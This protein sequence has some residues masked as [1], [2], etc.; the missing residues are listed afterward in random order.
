[1]FLCRIQ[2]TTP[3][4]RPVPPERRRG[5]VIWF[6]LVYHVFQVEHLRHCSGCFPCTLGQIGAGLSRRGPSVKSSK[7]DGHCSVRWDS[8]L[9][10]VQSP[11]SLLTETQTTVGCSVQ[12]QIQVTCPSLAVSDTHITHTGW[13]EM[14]FFLQCAPW[15]SVISV[16]GLAL[17]D[18]QADYAAFSGHMTTT[19]IPA[20]AMEQVI[21]H[22]WDVTY[23]MPGGRVQGIIWTSTEV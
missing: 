18:A 8:A 23:C 6:N 9:D 14:G 1:M 3:T 2:P 10:K 11:V 17:S 7:P 21:L 5:A 13:I 22:G 12:G 4:A 19:C 16:T 15:P 20:T